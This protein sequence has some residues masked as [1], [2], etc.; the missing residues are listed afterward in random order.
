[1]DTE[2]IFRVVG[3]HVRQVLPHLEHHQ[4]KPQDSLR[5]LGANSL[6]RSEIV[7]MTLESLALNVPLTAFSRAENLGDVVGILHARLQP[8]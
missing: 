3:N 5:Q 2:D 1:M 6:D 4:L 8:A 7:M